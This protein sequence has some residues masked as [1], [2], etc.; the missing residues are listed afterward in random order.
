MNGSAVVRL[1]LCSVLAWATPALAAEFAAEAEVISAEPI[2]RLQTSVG[3]A[4]SCIDRPAPTL[5]LTA[6]LA[7]D[8]AAGG[9]RRQDAR[10]IVEGYRV[11]YRWDGRVYQ[12]TL[13]EDPGPT[14]PV[15]V[16][17]H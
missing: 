12:Q 13:P 3:R 10:E 9:C 14:L 8:L 2:V 16:Q 15:A 5:G 11:T 1:V 17:I 6:L 4:P 7:W